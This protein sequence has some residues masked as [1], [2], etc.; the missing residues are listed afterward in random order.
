[1]GKGALQAVVWGTQSVLTAA[2]SFQTFIFTDGDDEFLAKHTGEPRTWGGTEATGP[3]GP[4]TQRVC[5]SPILM[6]MKPLS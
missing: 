4:F 3:G 5:S 6:Q 2:F 1:M